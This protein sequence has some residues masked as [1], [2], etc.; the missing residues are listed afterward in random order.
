V[1]GAG[2]RGL[3]EVEEF[4]GQR[5]SQ[6]VVLLR[7]ER[8]LD[9]LPR[10]SLGTIPCPLETG[11]RCEAPARVLDEP[12]AHVLCDLAPAGD[13]GHRIG[14]IPRSE[15]LVNDAGENVAQLNQAPRPGKFGDRVAELSPGCV[16]G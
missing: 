1:G 4:E 11:Q 16:P 7:I 10:R 6:Q 9:L 13:K 12:L 14:F 5:R 3:D 2:N 15:F 8:V